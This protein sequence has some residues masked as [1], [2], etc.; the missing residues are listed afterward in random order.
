MSEDWD[1]DNWDF[2]N[3]T[4]ELVKQRKA[5]LYEKANEWCLRAYRDFLAGRIDTADVMIGSSE[6]GMPI[7]LRHLLQEPNG[8]V[9]E[10]LEYWSKI[11]ADVGRVLGCGLGGD[12]LMYFDECWDNY[13]KRL[14]LIVN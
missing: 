14:A 7:S 6:D 1:N 3:M 5:V 9:S 4:D 8:P 2:G 13:V 11:Y 12:C 10:E